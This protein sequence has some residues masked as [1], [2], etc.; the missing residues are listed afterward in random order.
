[1]AEVTGSYLHPISGQHIVHDKVYINEGNG[2]H[3]YHGTFIAP[4]GG[5]YEFSMGVTVKIGSDNWTHINMMR[6]GI[7]IGYLFFDGLATGYPWLKET[8]SILVHLNVGDEVWIQVT[9]ANGAVEIAT[10]G[11]H[12]YFSGYLIQ[13]DS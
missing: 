6:N 12:T 10:T 8:E 5:L 2:Y 13:G 11:M 9:R 1:M 4:I 3:S 7:A